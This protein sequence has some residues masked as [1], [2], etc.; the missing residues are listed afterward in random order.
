MS[1]NSHSIAG[2]G[3]SVVWCNHSNTRYNGDEHKIMDP[4]PNRQLRDT[5]IALLLWCHNIA[6]SIHKSSL[7]KEKIEI[8]LLWIMEWICLTYILK[9]RHYTRVL[10]WKCM[11]SIIIYNLFSCLCPFFLFTGPGDS[12]IG[13]G[14]IH[15][16]TT[17]FRPGLFPHATLLHLPSQYQHCSWWSYSDRGWALC[18]S[19]LCFPVF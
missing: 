8:A 12:R 1:S 14:V 11:L 19:L 13:L 6:I 3:A 4:W 16:W 18:S 15:N 2:W 9:K 17:I 10:F 5:V 7:C